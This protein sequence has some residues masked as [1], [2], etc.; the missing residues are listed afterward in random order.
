MLNTYL[1]QSN[2]PVY[3]I[4]LSTNNYK[5]FLKVRKIVWREKQTS[6]TDWNRKQMWNYQTVNL[7]YDVYG[8][9]F[10]GKS[11]QHARTHGSCEKRDDG[12]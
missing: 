3:Y 1:S 10:N 9:G 4:Q 8:K 5:P 7:N 12:N 2:Y 6:E 11:E